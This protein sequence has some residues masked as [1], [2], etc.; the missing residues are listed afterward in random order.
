MSEPLLCNCHLVI[1]VEKGLQY[2][3]LKNIFM[4]YMRANVNKKYKCHYSMKVKNKY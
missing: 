4:K 1:T 2:I 3:I